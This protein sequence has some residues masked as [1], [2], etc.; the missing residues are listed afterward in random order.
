MKNTVKQITKA[1]VE[2]A[3]K[4][5][6]FYLLEQLHSC[7]GLCLNCNHYLSCRRNIKRWG[8]L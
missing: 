7:D 4:E 2:K 5:N 1:D 3:K 8:L 6:N